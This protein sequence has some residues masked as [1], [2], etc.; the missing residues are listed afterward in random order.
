MAVSTNDRTIEALSRIVRAIQD[1]EDLNVLLKAIMSESKELLHC[2]ASSLFLYDPEKNDLYFEVVVGGDEGIR[3]IRVPVGAG[4]VGAA[5]KENKTQIVLD[6]SKDSRHFKVDSSGFVTRN[7]IAAPMV[8]DDKLIGVLEVLN[9][10]GDGTFDEIDAKILEIMAEHA[11]AA[12]QKA[13]L[14][15]ENM[16]A[17]RLAA[18]GTASAS[19]AHYIKNILTQWRGSAS[20][21]DMGLEAENFNMV[22]QS[23]PIMRRSTDKISKLVQDMLTISR[24]REPEREPVDL[25]EMVRHIISESQAT[26][27][28]YDIELQTDLDDSV[29]VASLDP[30]RMHDSILNLVGNAMEAIQEHGIENAHVKVTTRYD[31][32]TNKITVIVE[33]DGPGM[34]PEVQARVFEPFFSTKGSRGTGLGLAVVNKTAEEH[35]GKLTLDSILGSGTTFTMELP[36]VAP[37]GADGPE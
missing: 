20:L 15:Q 17:Q 36:Y 5:A 26:A 24:E 34:P 12:I 33:D 31:S 29:P 22:K 35:D 11:A 28:K 6:T 8:R 37:E 21:I 1:V 18:L 25:N 13:Q 4:I 16:K 3:A 10:C 2:E 14:I 19:L 27:D 30:G 9:K 23:W 32:D 7:L